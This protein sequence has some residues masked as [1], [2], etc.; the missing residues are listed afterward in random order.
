MQIAPLQPIC[1]VSLPMSYMHRSAKGLN[2]E[3]TASERACSF[4]LGMMNKDFSRDTRHANLAIISQKP[5]K[6]VFTV[7]RQDPLMDEG[8]EIDTA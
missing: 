7:K 3:I 6:V 2:R 1:A 4:M 8:M 5:L